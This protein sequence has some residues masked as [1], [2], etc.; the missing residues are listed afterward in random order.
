MY[1]FKRFTGIA[2]IQRSI[3]AMNPQIGSI[4]I[5]GIV[6]IAIIYLI[7]GRNARNA[8]KFPK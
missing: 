4:I 8:P 7:K 6:K 5:K 1:E 2:K 3:E